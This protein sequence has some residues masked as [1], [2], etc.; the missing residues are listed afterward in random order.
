MKLEESPYLDVLAASKVQE[1]LELMRRP[2]DEPVTREVGMEICQRRGLAAMMTGGIASLGSNYIL[3]FDSVDCSTGE[4]LAARQIEIDSQEDVLSAVGQAT[5]DLGRD[6]VESLASSESHDPLLAAVTTSSLEA[7]QA[8]SIGMGHRNREGDNAAIPFL[9]QAVEL[10]PSFAQAHAR[11]GSLYNNVGRDEKG[12]Q[13]LT[14]AFELVGEVS[15]PERFYILTLYY[16][17]VVGDY[18][19]A[20]EICRQW[21]RTYPGD[22]PPRIH[23]AA[24]YRDLGQYEKSLQYGLEATGLPPDDKYAWQNVAKT[25]VAMGRLDE[26]RET[27]DA[28]EEEQLGAGSLATLRAHIAM[29]AGD[30]QTLRTEFAADD[31]TP[32]EGYNTARLG[33]FLAG[34]GR[35]AEARSLMQH[36]VNMCQSSGTVPCAN[37]ARL[38][39]AQAL[40]DF[41]FPDAAGDLVSQALEA[42]PTEDVLQEQDDAAWSGILLA[43]LGRRQEAEGLMAALADARPQDTIIQEIFLPIFA[44]LVSLDEA[45]PDGA[46]EALETARP[47]GRPAVLRARGRSYMELGR[48]DL[49]VVELEKLASLTTVYDSVHAQNLSRLWLAR[50]HLA[51]DNS[52]AARKAYEE[53]F[54]LMSEADEGIPL[55]EKARQE[56][57]TIP[58][59]LG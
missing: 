36:A 23:M 13:H 21:T 1:T 39:L 2:V 8:F 11:L 52:E 17:A 59:G 18:R 34:K 46:L 22:A 45:D 7:L 51:N 30:E 14:R 20:N 48:P 5:G 47:Y 19:K 43:E 12:R 15:E 31:G 55:I 56:Y 9:Q 58:D 4:S 53:F 29:A 32:A 37:Y 28:M 50:A 42:L 40:I 38:G 6:L 10:D 16:G 24:R 33:W 41:G 44:A 25:Y 49:A 3:T 26:A 35:L 27:V 57:A 54:T